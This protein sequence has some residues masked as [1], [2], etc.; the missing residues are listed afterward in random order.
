MPIGGGPSEEA[1]AER[2]SIFWISV[3]GYNNIIRNSYLPFGFGMSNFLINL[4]DLRQLYV[5]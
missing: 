1:F 4:G 3:I 5:I 2:R